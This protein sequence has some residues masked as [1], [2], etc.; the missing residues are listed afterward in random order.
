M[1][2]FAVMP[3]SDYKDICDSVRAKTGGTENLKSGEVAAA[4]AG[5]QAGGGFPELIFET[6]FEVDDAITSGASS[7]CTIS[8]GFTT[9][10]K[11]ATDGEMLVAFFEL[12]NIAD[13]YTPNDKDVLRSMQPLLADQYAGWTGSA[14]VSTKLRNGVIEVI[15]SASG[16]Y[17]TSRPNQFT[18]VTVNYRLPTGQHIAPGI[19]TFK[20]YRTGVSHA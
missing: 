12:T 19:Y 3:Y 8:T 13:G 11:W 15:G 18:S 17:F 20:L 9:E 14:Y 7:V 2:D 10:E 1:S 6:T 5:I 4:I 16:L